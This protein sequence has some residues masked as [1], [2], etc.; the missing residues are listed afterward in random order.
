MNPHLLH[1]WRNFEVRIELS[2]INR[3][4]VIA[5]YIIDRKIGFI[6]SWVLDE[7]RIIYDISFEEFKKVVNSIL[8]GTKYSIIDKKLLILL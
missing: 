5:E 4:R 3:E 7:R 6:Y 2:S 1:D 8:V